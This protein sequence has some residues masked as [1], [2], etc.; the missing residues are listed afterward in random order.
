M[1]KSKARKKRAHLARNGVRDVSLSRGAQPSFSTHERMT[2][3][4]KD[5]LQNIKHKKR[6]PYDHYSDGRD[7]FFVPQSCS[8]L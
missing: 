7:S 2:K 6:N 5:R 4:K 3:S 8:F 1:A